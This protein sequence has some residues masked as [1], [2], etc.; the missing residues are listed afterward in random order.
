MS[1]QSK[2]YTP[3]ADEFFYGFDYEIDC[4]TPS[5]GNRE[6]SKETY[7]RTGPRIYEKDLIK[8]IKDNGVRVKHLDKGDVESLG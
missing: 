7:G 4:I 3:I 6:W 8:I 1:S 2:Y 5:D